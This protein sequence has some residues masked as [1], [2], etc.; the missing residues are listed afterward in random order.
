M[1]AKAADL[2]HV[3]WLGG[4]ACAGKTTVARRLAERCG[5]SLYS[6][7]DAFAAHRERA[8]PHRHPVFCR[9]MDRPAE[10]LW[11]APPEEQA[12][13][14]LA[15]Y[16]DELQMVVDDVLALPRERPVLVEG[17]GL[18]PARLAPLL[19]APGH[20]LWLIATPELRR[21]RYPERGSYVQ[22]LLARCADPAQAFARWMERDD[23]VAAKL[24]E[25]AAARGLAWISVDGE[26][27]VGAVVEEAERRLGLSAEA[28]SVSRSG[29]EPRQ[30]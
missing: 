25:D 27:D 16:E 5:L 10:V 19:A 2:A 7:D 13:E 8:D 12:A 26:R 20:A 23:R 18:L 9:L 22:E 3:R 6:T 17:V 29:G 4:S 24:G 1:T 14:L 15:F 30:E 28:T 11:K 21:N